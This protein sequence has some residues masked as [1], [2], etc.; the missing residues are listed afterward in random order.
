MLDR[1]AGLAK[2]RGIACM[3]GYYR[4]T[5]KNK[6]VSGLFSDMGF[7]SGPGAPEDGSRW[8]LDLG[9]YE[10]RNSIIRVNHE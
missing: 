5:A 2:A 3:V 8:L 9:A 1:I 4:P 6:M 7:R 10:N